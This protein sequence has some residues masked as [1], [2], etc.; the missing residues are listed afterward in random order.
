MPDIPSCANETE[1]F[2]SMQLKPELIEC[3]E[4]L[5]TQT[6]DSKWNI[7]AVL[8][9][10]SHFYQCADEKIPTLPITIE[11]YDT[12][13]EYYEKHQGNEL[14]LL[15][16]SYQT[17][18]SD[19]VYF[20]V[21]KSS[22][23]EEWG[24]TYAQSW[25]S[26]RSYQNVTHSHEGTDIMAL[27]NKRGYYPI[28]SM[29]DGVV[30]K[31]G[32][33]EKGGYRVG[34]RS[35]HGAYLYYAHL[36]RYADG[37]KEGDTVKAGQLLGFMGDSGYSKVEGTVGNFDVHLHLGMYLKTEHYEELSVNPYWI[38]RLIE[39]QTAMGDY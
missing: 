10:A 38:L 11:E 29:T 14:T 39:T 32:W 26:E 2:R 30:E 7:L 4:K 37:L 24:I 18:L 25:L 21:M 36:Y 16:K 33:L 15:A 23:T 6:E 22:R 20:P 12:L 13:A 8:M 3:L 1:E 31:L 5:D 17:I 19:L 9:A 28:V 27:N 35:P 34:I